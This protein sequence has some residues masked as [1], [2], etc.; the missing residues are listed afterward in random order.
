MAGRKAGPRRR[1]R[2]VY[3]VAVSADGFLA[4]PDGDVGWLDRPMPKGFYGM[5]K[6][7]KSVDTLV[8]GRKT[9]DV[10]Q[11]LGGSPFPG[12]T[13]Y[14]FSRKR[15]KIT[16]PPATKLV[17]ETPKAF[18]AKLRARPGKDIWLMGGGELFGAFL[19]AGE[20]DRISLHVIPVFIGEGIPLIGPR[21]RHVEL[22]RTSH[23]I[24][25]DGVVHLNYEVV[26]RGRRSA[27]LG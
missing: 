2:I 27:R 24:F 6:F 21:H 5:E 8:M 15:R 20:V 9:W 4:R 3:E 19:D 12:M 7:F 25:P 18:A 22:R 17:R 14:V 10:A 23:R 16:A 13:T 1:R 11:K 26:R